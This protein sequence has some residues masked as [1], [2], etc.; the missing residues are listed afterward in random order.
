ME[1]AEGSGAQRGAIDLI[2]RLGQR[3]DGR[4][5]GTVKRAEQTAS[6]PFSGTLDLLRALEAALDEDPAARTIRGQGGET[7]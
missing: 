3:A 2:L 7:S 1:S 5:E 6:V 4:L